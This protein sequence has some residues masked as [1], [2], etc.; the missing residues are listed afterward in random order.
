MPLS[1]RGEWMSGKCEC[2]EHSLCRRQYSGLGKAGQVLC[3]CDCH[4]VHGKVRLR[5]VYFSSSGERIALPAPFPVEVDLPGCVHASQVNDEVVAKVMAEHLKDYDI[6]TTEVDLG[7]TVLD[8]APLPWDS[9][10]H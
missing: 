9:K 8:D 6:D 10:I 3:D 7:W 2:S 4:R 5:L 1:P